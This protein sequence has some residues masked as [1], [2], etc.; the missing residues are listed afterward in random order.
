MFDPG[1]S[2]TAGSFTVNGVAIAVTRDDSVNTVL[3]KITASAAGVTATYDAATQ[4]VTLDSNDGGTG[5]IT[6]GGD[7]SGFLAAVKLDGTAASSVSTVS[8]SS[9]T[10]ALGEMAEYASV[11]A[12]TLT[13]NGQDIAIDPA[14]TTI[15]GLVT[16]LN[17]LSGVAAQLNETSGTIDIWSETTGASFTVADT[18][19]L[20]GAL[21][22][23][24]GTYTG[25]ARAIEQRHDPHRH[26]DDLELDRRRHESVGGGDAAQRCA[27]RSSAATA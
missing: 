22:L 3:A 7:T 18:S 27:L 2:V 24:A 14:T 25:T 21:G 20:L 1:L 15:D 26:L 5:P 17:G 8:Y 13:V 16:A 19:G 10:S 9:F 23:A 11:T 4:R 12:G 6:F